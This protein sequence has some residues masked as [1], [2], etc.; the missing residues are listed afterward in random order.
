ASS[1]IPHP[2]RA[3]QGGCDKSPAIRTKRYRSNLIVVFHRF[4]CWLAGGGVPET[5]HMIPGSRREAVPIGTERYVV[6][7]FGMLHN[8]ADLLASV[9]IPDTGA[10]ISG[11]RGQEIAIRGKGQSRYGIDVCQH[12]CK[13]L[14]RL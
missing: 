2:H 12:R 3:I 14:A 1:G 10:I 8:P 6:D 7:P 5:G 13:W 4:G 9:C 11:S